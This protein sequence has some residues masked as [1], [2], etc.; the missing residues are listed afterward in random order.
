LKILDAHT[1]AM[2]GEERIKSLKALQYKTQN[3]GDYSGYHEVWY[4]N[5]NGA[6]RNDRI[7]LSPRKLTYSVVVSS[8]DAWEGS[9]FHDRGDDG[10]S[11]YAIDMQD[12]RDIRGQSI[13]RIGWLKQQ[14]SDMFVTFRSRIDGGYQYELLGRRN[15]PTG[16][17]HVIKEIWPTGTEREIYINRETNLISCRQQQP[18]RDGRH[19]LRDTEE[20]YSEYKLIDCYLMPSVVIRKI[21]GGRDAIGDQ[22]EIVDYKVNLALDMT[23]FERPEN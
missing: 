22:Y 9:A 7:S 12:T 2:G 5:R 19:G 23:V 17:E 13:D 3:L 11:V 10:S 20:C 14:I 15:G 6:V 4:F 16:V 18:Y 8:T 21:A 1:K